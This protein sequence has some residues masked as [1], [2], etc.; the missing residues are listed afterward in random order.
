[1]RNGGVACKLPVP[2]KEASPEHQLNPDFINPT[3]FLAPSKPPSSP[4]TVLTLPELPEP[5][6]P[7]HFCTPPFLTRPCFSGAQF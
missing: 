2:V 4:G 1:M 5:P 6:K 3:H 7:Q